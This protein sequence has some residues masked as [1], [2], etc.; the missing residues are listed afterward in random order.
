MGSSIHAQQITWTPTS[1]PTF[2]A[3]V[4]LTP[5]RTPVPLPTLTAV[6]QTM[7]GVVRAG[8]ATVLYPAS[9]Q[10]VLETMVNSEALETVSLALSGAGLEPVTINSDLTTTLIST[11]PAVIE[12][13][14][15]VPPDNL[16][17]LFGQLQY[18]W[19]V[20]TQTG[21]TGELNGEITFN[22]GRF[23]WQE[24]PVGTSDAMI[25]APYGVV[26]ANSLANQLLP[27]YELL[28]TATRTSVNTNVLVYPAEVTPLCEVNDQGESVSWTPNRGISRPC[29]DALAERVITASGFDLVNGRTARE[30]IIRLWVDEAYASVWRNAQIPEWFQAGLASFFDPTVKATWR[31]LAMNATRTQQLFSLEMMNQPPTR[32]DD[33]VLWQA[34]AFGMALYLF[35][36]LGKEGLIDLSLNPLENGDFAETLHTQTGV[37]PEGLISAWST[38]LF[39]ERAALVYVLTA[40]QP[41][42]STP[43]P[44]STATIT[45]T[46]TVTFT[47]SAT[48]TPTSALLPTNTAYPTVTPVDTLPPPTPSVTPRS[49]SSLVTPAPAPTSETVE[50]VFT[51]RL[52]LILV[53]LLVITVLALVIIRIGRR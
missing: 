19:Q 5:S 21:E 40:Y 9:V 46:P 15:E 39:S 26:D 29:D 32:E 33:Q 20:T 34:Q 8:S 17:D 14:W 16:P 51:P 22:D 30:Q 1:T 38:W 31:D 42:T 7:D 53:I 25:V 12:Y 47:A 27:A 52:I 36:Q 28:S 50:T 23:L 2:T 35:D 44:T 37:T 41:A 6:T 10:F 49:A 3:S 45:H 4:T 18:T 24:V 11:D 48:Y 43:T 13:F